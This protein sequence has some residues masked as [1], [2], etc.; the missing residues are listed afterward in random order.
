[1]D[2]PPLPL[3]RPQLQSVHHATGGLAAHRLLPSFAADGEHRVRAELQLLDALPWIAAATSLEQVIL[4]CTWATL[5]QHPGRVLRRLAR[6]R[7]P[8]WQLSLELDCPPDVQEARTLP[9]LARRCAE[10]GIGLGLRADPERGACAA[11]LATAASLRFLTLPA[12]AL[13]DPAWPGPGV[14]A[15]ETGQRFTDVP[16]LVTDVVGHELLAAARR[17]GACWVCGPA[18]APVLHLSQPCRASVRRRARLLAA[19]TACSA[20]TLLAACSSVPQPALP[21]GS[22]RVTANDP[23]RLGAFIQGTQQQTAAVAE[24]SAL[25]QELTDLRHHVRELAAA[26]KQLLHATAPPSTNA[27][28]TDS[29]V[30]PAMPTTFVQDAGTHPACHSPDAMVERT[31]DRTSEGMVFRVFQAFGRARFTPAGDFARLLRQAVHDAD[32]IVVH[33]YTDSPVA[34]AGNRRVAWARAEAARRWLLDQGVAPDR[35]LTRHSAAGEFLVDPRAA[36]SGAWN[37]RVEITL[38]GQRV[39]LAAT[40]GRED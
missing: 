9:G 30:R 18:V 38:R 37:R 12:V 35:I 23:A 4:V 8:G 31:I 20:A 21:D 6:L 19:T 25:Y 26:L 2:P 13:R 36:G 39:Q 14:R 27:A 34:D 15:W 33:A 11:R 7:P 28:P 32:S 22:H 3:P 5:R 24:R 29:S 10:A 17:G 1:M 40:A 16:L